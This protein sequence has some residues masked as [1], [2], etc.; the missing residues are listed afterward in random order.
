MK[1]GYVGLGKMGFNMV[2]RLLEK[3]HEVVAF[4]RGEEPLK[5]I[6]R[7]GAETV[8]SLKSLVKL[9]TPPRL[10]W[11]M[12]PYQAVDTVLNDLIPWLEKGDTIIDGGNSPYKESMRRAMELGEMGIGFLDVGVSGGPGGARNG[13]CIMV[14]GK[15][16]VFKRFEDLFKDLSVE[17]GY[18]YMGKSG[19]GH[20]VKM[21]HNGIEYGMM[22][23]IA[24]GFTLLRASPFGLDLTNV[25]NIFNH[26]SVIESRLVGWLKKAFEEYGED[27]NQISGSVSYSGEGLW[28]IETAKELGIPV[29]II[30]ESLRIRIE[31]Q[32]NPSYTGQ[33]LSAMRHQFGG[34]EVFKK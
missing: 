23:A 10:I 4:N 14:G 17:G 22:Q 24:E 1:L 3:G 9:L 32:E 25:S 19:A 27:L 13:A 5:N 28:T 31:S 8:N 33:I 21:V 34:H 16:E 15:R 11:L 30:E 29:P 2:Q 6:A 18:G 26:G 7:Y 12:I 20:F